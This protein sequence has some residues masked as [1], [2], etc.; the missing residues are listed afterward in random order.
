TT[1]ATPTIAQIA[2][3]GSYWPGPAV[4]GSWFDPAR[5]GEGIVLQYL[6]NGKALLTWFTYPP[7]GEPGEQAWLITD[8]GQVQGSKIIF[9]TVYRPQGGL[10]GDGFDPTR[11]TN[12]P[13][14][15]LELEF[16]NCNS[17]TMRFAGPPAFGNGERTMTRLTALD[18]LNCNGGRTLNATG[19]RALTGLRAKSGAWYVPARSGEGW[20]V[21]EL[22]DG[23]TLVYW[24]TYDP[25]GRQAWTIG[26]GTRDG[27]RL[28]IADNIITRGT[29][30]GSGFDAA[31]VQRVRWGSLAFTFSSCN[32]VAVSYNAIQPGYGSASRAGS[33]LASLGGAAC[34]DGNP[35]AR[36]N[37]SWV[38]AAALPA[39]AQSEHASTVLDG[40]LYTVGGFGDLRGFKRYDPSNNSWTV[41][42][43][44]PGAR[45]HLAAFAFEGGVYAFGGE[46]S[47]GGD[48][49]SAAFRYDVAANRWETRP[50]ISTFNFGTHAAVLLGRAY[51]G[52]PDGGMQEYDPIQRT[53]RRLSPALPQRQRDHSQTVAFMG[54]IWMIAGRLP[55]TSS[56]SIYDPV[57]ER[58]R[59]GP[60][61]NRPRGGFAAAVVGEQI[62]IGGGEVLSAPIRL[63][64]K[65]EIYTAGADAW[66]LGP[67][68][69]LA[70]HGVTGA[71]LNGSFYLVSGSTI[72]GSA[73]GQTGRVFSISL[74]P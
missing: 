66:R 50:E 62:V 47:A 32:N 35:Q 37:G 52:A 48:E 65:T 19:G 39:P 34:L 49:T 30:F 61:I 22:A 23:R 2:T 5:D 44:L 20:M 15:T 29:R 14:G 17:L 59:A 60:P 8:L 55:E 43:A 3:T 11:I 28:D 7:A 42:P 56:V 45:D 16:Q 53:V 1:L 33:L 46:V 72:A 6:A 25:Q 10:F 27:S 51:I 71:A 69:P 26:V 40:K 64:G 36:T 73:A 4:S 63:E 57:T 58:W 13:W 31:A 18:Q 12:T 38:E 70:V 67:D 54:E 24:F 9:P 41:L 21:E 68:L 74:L